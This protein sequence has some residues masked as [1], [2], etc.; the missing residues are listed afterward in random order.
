[1]I[2]RFLCA[3][4]GR[5][6]NETMA[7]TYT[8]WWLFAV[9]A[10]SACSSDGEAPTRRSTSPGN[11]SIEFAVAGPDSFCMQSTCG[12]APTIDVEDPSGQ[13]LF[14]VSASCSSV[15][16]ETCSTSPCPGFACQIRGI[17]VSGAKLDWDGRYNVMST[18]GG[19]TACVTYAYANPGRYTAKMC[20]TPGKITGAD[21]GV[22]QCETSGPAKCGSV[23][24]DFP[25]STVVQGTVG[26]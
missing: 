20:A 18:C 25:S 1:V 15:S 14:S 21:A 17:Q 26:P 8:S 9:F 12:E 13:S 2:A 3:W 10:T 5:P 4:Q 19:S 6:E 16:C 22:P 7:R 24:F 11:V 23:E